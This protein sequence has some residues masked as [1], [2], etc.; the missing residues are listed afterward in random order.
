MSNNR[1]IRPALGLVLRAVLVGVAA[2][3][4][5]T[6]APPSTQ[7]AHA[8]TGTTQTERARLHHRVRVHHVHRAF[9]IARHQIGDAY[10]YGAA[11][12]RRFDC[13]G[14]TYYA[15]H[16]AGFRHLPRTSS[17]QAHFV[18]HIRRSQLR[19]G[20]FIFFT[21]GGSVY[22]VGIYAGRHHGHRVVIHAPYSGT[23]VRRER[24]WTSHWFAGT[25]R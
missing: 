10:S 11:G 14:L 12:P 13:S 3:G 7:S 2:V 6:L 16:R 8:A 4:L 23:H 15:F 5:L 25:L 19:R 17:Q 1:R 22:H 24:I 18:R 20:D 21:S 9:R